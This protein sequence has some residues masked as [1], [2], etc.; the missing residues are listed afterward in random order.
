LRCC[1]VGVGKEKENEMKCL[2]NFFAVTLMLIALDARSVTCT[3][4]K[5]SVCTSGECKPSTPSKTWTV[6]GIDHLQR[7]DDKGC[8]RHTIK[9]TKSGA[10]TNVQIPNTPYI[11]RYDEQLKFTEVNAFGLDLIVHSGVCKP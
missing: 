4:E 3:V 7:C 6:I 8:D 11:L 10:F 9:R 5:S 1:R 2:K